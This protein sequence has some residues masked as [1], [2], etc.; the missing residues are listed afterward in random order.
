MSFAAAEMGVA[1]FR[2]STL[3]TAFVS[4]VLF[5]SLAGC[6]STTIHSPNQPVSLTI[7][8]AISLKEPLDSFAQ[9][10]NQQHPDVRVVCNYGASGTLQQ[11]IEQGAPVDIFISAGEKQ[12]DTLQS[13]NLLTAGTRR[14]LIANQLVLIAPAN[15][16]ALHNFNDLAKPSIKS[17][18]LGEPRTV[19]AGM[20]AQQV[21]EHFHLLAALKS[22]I[23][24][25]ANVRQVLAYVE[26]GNASAGLVYATDARISTRV[27]VV[28]T[29][30][31]ASHDPILYPVALLK[32]S[33][34]P[35]AARALL[36]ALESPPSLVLFE[37]Y[38]FT[39]PLAPAAV[40]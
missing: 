23:V 17:I 30:P 10:Y 25:A 9:N 33:K 21:L 1:K 28:A 2:I 38:G 15:S 37:K 4:V 35:E 36:D 26:T 24:Y 6:A 11:Q 19:P 8:A 31:P 22:K 5:A 39:P 7:S 27:R 18:A 34:S 40:H 14:D 29:A 16:A 32:T 13:E 20:Y 12:M 3:M